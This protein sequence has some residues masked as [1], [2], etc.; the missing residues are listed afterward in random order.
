M[1]MTLGIASAIVSPRR[2]GPDLAG[3][4]VLHRARRVRQSA[5]KRITI[6]RHRSGPKGLPREQLRLVL[7]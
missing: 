6:S 2:D 5:A 1:T 3:A 7:I 4:S